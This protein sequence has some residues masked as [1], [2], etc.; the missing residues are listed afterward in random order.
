MKFI[1]GIWGGHD[2]IP[3][4]WDRWLE[5]R[6]GQMFV[7]EVDGKA[8]GMNRVKL[9]EDGSAW[10]EGA[11]VH[12]AYR[13]K[14]V[15]T[16][17]G[18]NSMKYVDER[19][20][21]VYRLA[22]RSTNRPAHRQVARMSFREVARVSV[23]ERGS[24]SRLGPQTGVRAV[25]PDEAVA[26]F[27]S[28]KRS[29]EYEANAGL[30]CSSFTSMALSK[31]MFERRVGRGEVLVS[32]DAMAITTKG[33]EGRNMWKEVCFM[34]GKAESAA[35]LVKHVLGSAPKSKDVV[36]FLPVGSKLAS[37][38]RGLGFKRSTSLIIFERRVPKG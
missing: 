20:A 22:S 37:M 13:G 35:R 34:S 29:K 10:F 12:P 32:D 9:V 21:T 7:A 30:I 14:G 16:A 5:D 24:T 38:L 8:V 25:R 19:G 15:A 27:R 17:L 3:H 2:Y 4:V 23:Y 11:R 1:K 18:E 26:T 28:F 6:S 33:E 36:V 31:E